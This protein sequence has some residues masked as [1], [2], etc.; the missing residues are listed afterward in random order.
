MI[1]LGSGQYASAIFI[2]GGMDTG[3]SD[4]DIIFLGA[5]D[6]M[7]HLTLAGPVKI[8]RHDQVGNTIDTEMLQLDLT[9]SSSFGTVHLRNSPTQ[10]SLGKIM[11]VQP[12]FFPASSFFDVFFEIDI[13]G[14]TFHNNNALRVSDNT[15]NEIPPLDAEFVFNGSVELFDEN[16][17]PT[18]LRILQVLH[19]PHFPPSPPVGGEILPVDMTALFVAGALTN[20]LWILP[21]LGGIAG[22]AIALFKVKRRNHN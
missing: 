20:A 17:D 5:H 21:T 1:I 9:G 11:G 6:I 18:D 7:L 4:A 22:A 14:H 10:P 2:P 13:A 12:D 16:G 3:P 15:I 19:R 8:L